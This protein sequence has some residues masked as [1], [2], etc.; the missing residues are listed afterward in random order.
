MASISTV[1]SDLL[2]P[3]TPLGGVLTVVFDVHIHK[4]VTD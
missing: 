1:E 4:K 3:R 2:Y